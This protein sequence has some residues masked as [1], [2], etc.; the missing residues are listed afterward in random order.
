VLK[1]LGKM[2]NVSRV[3][4]IPLDIDQTK[5]DMHSIYMSFKAIDNSEILN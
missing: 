3:T 2:G 5:N 1:L 4:N